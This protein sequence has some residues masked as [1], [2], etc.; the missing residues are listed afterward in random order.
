MT[1]KNIEKA[2]SIITREII[3]N[4]NK[5]SK[6]VVSLDDNSVEFMFNHQFD[7]CYINNCQVSSSFIDDETY[8]EKV[9]EA[10]IGED[11]ARC[12]KCELSY[13][14]CP[15]GGNECCKYGWNN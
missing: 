4:G 13:Q 2:L 8:E 1:T 11:D 3:N 7:E 12:R 14:Y 15:Y 9:T 6:V 5:F 10:L